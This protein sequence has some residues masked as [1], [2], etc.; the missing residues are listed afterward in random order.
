MLSGP[1]LIGYSQFRILRA[2]GYIEG[3]KVEKRKHVLQPADAHPQAICLTFDPNDNEVFYVGTDEGCINKCSLNYSFHRSGII[4]AHDGGVYSMQFSPF[5]P[6]FYLT[7]GNDWRIRFWEID[8]IEPIQEYVCPEEAVE[9]AR[10]S[11]LNSC[12]FVSCTKTAV[13]IWDLRKRNLKPSAI[14]TLPNGNIPLTIVRFSVDGRCL[15]VGDEEGNLFMGALEDMP[16]SPYYQVDEL[17]AALKPK[18]T[19]YEDAHFQSDN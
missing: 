4:Q 10:W 14:H 3:V 8:V 5:S 6:K 19:A 2:H 9:C 13:Q 7:C 11:P 15:I 18:L 17:E 16:I 12:I 1:H